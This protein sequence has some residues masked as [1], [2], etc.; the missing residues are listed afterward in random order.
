MRN[1]A[2]LQVWT[3]LFACDIARSRSQVATI[4]RSR[5]VTVRD[6]R[7]LEEATRKGSLALPKVPGARENLDNDGSRIARPLEELP[8]ALPDDS[9]VHRKRR[10]ASASSGSKLVDASR[11][12]GESCDC[13]VQT[14]AV[15]KRS[16][17]KSGGVESNTLASSD[18]PQALLLCTSCIPDA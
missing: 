4:N 13:S 6:P 16:V 15:F 8:H 3:W 12:S 7:T 11:R 18:G 1:H 17:R 9:Q 5:P 2:T 14:T 10:S